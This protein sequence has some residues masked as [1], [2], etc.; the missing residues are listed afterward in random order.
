MKRL[1]WY[2]F[3]VIVLMTSCAK[4][5]ALFNNNH[6]TS[7]NL[8]GHMANLQTRVGGADG[9]L[10]DAGDS[11]GVY[12]IAAT[13]GTLTAANIVPTGNKRY[14]A[15]AG[16]TATFTPFDGTPLTYPGDGTPVKFLAYHPYS[17]G[18]TSDFKLQIDLTDQSDQSAIDVLY[19]PITT[20]D[21]NNSTTGDVP[22]QFEHKMVKLI[23]NITN[24][25][26]VTEP[27]AN[28]VTVSIPGLERTGALDLTDG[29][30]TP[31][32]VLGTLSLPTTGTGATVIAEAILFPGATS[33][34]D[35]YFTNHA[36]QIFVASAPHALWNEGYLYTYDITLVNPDVHEASITGT[37]TP[38][39][40]GGNFPIDGIE[41]VSPL[42]MN[43]VKLLFIQGD[44]FDMG[45]PTSEPDRQSNETQHQVTLSSFYISENEITNELFCQF[46][47][48]TGVL[49]NGEG[50]VVGYGNQELIRTSLLGVEHDGSEWHPIT[51]YD[52]YPVNY[53]SWYGAKAFCDWAGGRLPT[54]AEWEFA[55]RAGTTTPFN[56]GNNLTTAQANYGDASSGHTQPV[57]SYAPNAWGLYD[58]H[59]N[60]WEWCN[61][62]YDSSIGT[63]AVINPTGPSTGSDRVRRGGSW[64]Q[65]ADWCRSATRY[66]GP[67]NI[68][69]YTN[70]QNHFGFRMAASL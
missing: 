28:G 70:L 12:M 34:I 22:L 66:P 65:P 52:N 59:G 60:V 67:P 13:P 2:M 21:Y 50:N 1:F 30:V 19:A 48:E 39:G 42:T 11:V 10:W 55:C 23:F 43:G 29:T 36:G 5:K 38:W 9:S 20:A 6:N 27:V 51:G 26:S 49:A 41:V 58:M 33:G 44:T 37:I 69:Y 46:L 47:N 25:T 32:G 17:A 53:V 57:G 16:A 64:S 15:S 45:S 62:W 31:S 7:V 8:T 24:G 61:D 54:E 3:T 68:Y 18:I 63:G 14:N 35:F 40:N 56:T 4:E